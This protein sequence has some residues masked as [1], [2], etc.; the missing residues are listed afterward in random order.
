M[1]QAGLFIV[2]NVA[3]GLIISIYGLSIYSLPNA[4]ALQW[5]L[6]T[7]ILLFAAANIVRGALFIGP[8]VGW[9]ASMVMFVFFVTPLINLVVYE[10][11]FFIS[12]HYVYMFLLFILY[13]FNF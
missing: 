6:F 5:S 9:L 13:F 3:V 11:S 1:V 7:I 8:F 10:F 4:Q 2:M 12:I